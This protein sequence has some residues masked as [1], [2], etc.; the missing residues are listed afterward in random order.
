MISKK[1]YKTRDKKVQNKS[2]NTNILLCLKKKPKTLIEFSIIEKHLTNTLDSTRLTDNTSSVHTGDAASLSEKQNV[3]NTNGFEALQTALYS[4]TGQPDSLGEKDNTSSDPN[5]TAT[6]LDLNNPE[7]V[8]SPNIL[9]NSTIS[10]PNI[11]KEKNLLNKYTFNKLFVCCKESRIES[12][13]SF[14]GCFYIGP[15]NESLSQTVA[16]NIRRTLLSELS[17]LAITAVEIDGVSHKYS[18]IPGVKETALDLICNL[19]SLV[20][21]KQLN[22]KNVNFSKKNKI[23]PTQK[24]ESGFNSTTT[25]EI[26]HKMTT[27]ALQNIELI[28]YLRVRGPGVV[29]A[30]DILLPSGIECVNPNQYIATLAEDGSLN[31]K[32]YIKEGK[33]FIKQTPKSLTTAFSKKATSNF[34]SPEVTM[35]QTQE[36]TSLT[37]FGVHNGASWATGTPL[38]VLSDKYPLSNNKLFSKRVVSEQSLAHSSNRIYLDS[39][40]MPVTKANAIVQI[41]EKCTD[42][43]LENNL[44]FKQLKNNLLFVPPGQSPAFVKSAYLSNDLESNSQAESSFYTYSQN[45]T[46]QANFFSSC[47][48]SQFNIMSSQMLSFDNSALSVGQTSAVDRDPNIGSSTGRKTTGTK[49]AGKTSTSNINIKQNLKPNRDWEHTTRKNPFFKIKSLNNSINLFPTQ[50]LT[51]VNPTILFTEKNKSQASNWRQC[52][53]ILEIWTNG[54]IH[55][56]EAL[57]NSLNFLASTFISLESVK[58]MGTMFKSDV[59]YCIANAKQKN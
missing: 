56:R 31:M 43:L 38:E 46:Q 2:L 9:A 4:T 32:L 34:I 24:K 15:F 54:S 51:Q 45:L 5:G 10:A 3:L 8:T 59:R 22:Q 36:K 17:G 16:H 6:Q 29:L 50:S 26:A 20:L 13:T 14:Y 53:I 44:T 41:N 47:Q 49:S 55:P 48:T 35:Q 28:G 11:I 21:K 57:K 40:F 33:N 12:P 39:V 52:H 27:G 18:T 30:S 37:T 19:Q 1:N 58:M 7:L 23:K 25:T 42:D